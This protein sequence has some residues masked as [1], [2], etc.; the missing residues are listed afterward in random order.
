MKAIYAG[1]SENTFRITTRIGFMM[2]SGKIRP[3]SARSRAGLVRRPWWSPVPG[4]EVFIIDTPGARLRNRRALR[5]V[6][7]PI[8]DFDALI[9]LC[10]TDARANR[11]APKRWD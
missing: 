11:R 7:S 2:H 4:S 5:I 1:F 9:L 3:T 6:E 8:G 10:P